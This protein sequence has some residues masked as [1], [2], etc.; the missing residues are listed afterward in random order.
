VRKVVIIILIKSGDIS[1]NKLF[2]ISTISV[3]NLLAIQKGA[4]LKVLAWSE[5]AG[6]VIST[7]IKFTVVFPVVSWW[8]LDEIT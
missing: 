2:T 1:A 7:A 3:S 4:W 6:K 8:M 5:V